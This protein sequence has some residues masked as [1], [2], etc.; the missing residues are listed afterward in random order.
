MPGKAHP[1]DGST[2]IGTSRQKLGGQRH[3]AVDDDA[4]QAAQGQRPFRSLRCDDLEAVMIEVEAGTLSLYV[5][6]VEKFSHPTQPLVGEQTAPT[7]F[8]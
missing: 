8:A 5:Q 2:V 1:Y 3:V 7:P 4:V 6:G